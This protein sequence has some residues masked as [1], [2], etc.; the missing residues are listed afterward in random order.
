MY[1]RKSVPNLC[2]GWFKL[3]LPETGGKKH[4][5]QG[6][7]QRTELCLS[8]HGDEEP[9]VIVIGICTR[10][11]S[12][13]SHNQGGQVLNHVVYADQGRYKAILMEKESYLLELSRYVVLNPARAG[14]VKDMEQWPW[15]SLG[16]DRNGLLPLIGN[17][18][19]QGWNCRASGMICAG[20]LKNLSKSC[21]SMCNP[22]TISVKFRALSG[23]QR[24]SRS[25]L[26][27]RSMTE[28]Q[29]LQQPTK[30]AAIQ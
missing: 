27:Y 19:A 24:P 28:M 20:K 1:D 8:T 22:I 2:Q 21:G 3:R 30:Q 14:R 25:H 10:N 17:L 23:G 9:L 11:F 16:S 13:T 4:R 12:P 7:G 18:C 6:Y 15:S 5:P 29:G 26:I